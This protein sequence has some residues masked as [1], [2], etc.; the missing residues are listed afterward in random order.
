[1]LLK[2]QFA[3]YLKKKSSQNRAKFVQNLHAT[4][5]FLCLQSKIKIAPCKTASV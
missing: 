1:M 2:Q 4:L 5:K 3:S